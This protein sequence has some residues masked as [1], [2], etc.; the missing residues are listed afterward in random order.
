VQWEGVPSAFTP[1]PF[2]LTMDTEKAQIDGLKVTPCV[3]VP[4][5]SGAKKK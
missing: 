2:L 4:A 5:H 1:S 3:A